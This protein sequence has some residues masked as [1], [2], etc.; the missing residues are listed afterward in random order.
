MN[1]E[2]Y[3]NAFTEQEKS[4]KQLLLTQYY[5]KKIEDETVFLKRLKTEQEKLIKK[6]NDI[7]RQVDEIEEENNDLEENDHCPNFDDIKLKGDFFQQ[8]RVIE[9]ADEVAKAQIAG[10]K[11][12]N[13]DLQSE[14]QV[15]SL[16]Y[17]HICAQNA[18]IQQKIANAEELRA[19]RESD[20]NVIRESIIKL[21]LEENKLKDMLFNI[22]EASKQKAEEIKKSAKESIDDIFT[23]REV[24]LSAV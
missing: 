11:T 2:D 24:L 6:L 12:C 21:E 18:D 16:K 14:I 19:S 7:T 1:M 17:N 5:D 13:N 3:D 22:K 10:L 15:N 9:A 8:L 20:L 4:D 23:Q